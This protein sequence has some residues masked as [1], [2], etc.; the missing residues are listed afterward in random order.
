M[1]LNNVSPATVN[2]ASNHI[3]NGK[4][5]DA[6]IMG[7]IKSGLKTPIIASGPSAETFAGLNNYGMN[8]EVIGPAVGSGIGV[9]DVSQCLHQGC[10]CPSF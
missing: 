3:T 1:D 8:I 2:E 4:T 9:E 10:F 7:G 5:T 6:A